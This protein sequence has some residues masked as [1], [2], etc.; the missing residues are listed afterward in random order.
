MLDGFDVWKGWVYCGFPFLGCCCDNW[1]PLRNQYVNYSAKAYQVTVLPKVVA[2]A[3]NQSA[4]ICWPQRWQVLRES[5]G[6][7]YEKSTG[8]LVCALDYNVW[9]WHETCCGHNHHLAT[10]YQLFSQNYRPSQVGE[11]YLLWW[12]C[13]WE[14]L[15]FFGEMFGFGLYIVQFYIRDTFICIRDGFSTTEKRVL[16]SL[17][18]S[19]RH[20]NCIKRRVV[21]PE[22]C[23]KITPL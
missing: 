4:C 12:K 19:K 2:N 17:Q 13:F 16:G 11:D 20:K 14:S 10:M 7:I 3:L 21:Y 8:R 23:R 9:R 1:P 5:R 22:Y 18:T 15:C 6:S